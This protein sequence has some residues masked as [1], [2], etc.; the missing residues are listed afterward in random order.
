MILKQRI[1][2]LSI[3]W[4][5]FKSIRIIYTQMCSTV[6]IPSNKLPIVIFIV[7]CYTIF[8]ISSQLSRF[9]NQTMQLTHFVGKN[10]QT[11]PVHYTQNEIHLAIVCA[12]KKF[13]ELAL[14]SIKSIMFNRRKSYTLTFHIFTD[15]A[16]KQLF[17]AYFSSVKN[18][19]THHPLFF[20]T[21]PSRFSASRP[22]RS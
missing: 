15:A 9:Q 10:F 22:R 14:T 11:P 1:P 16:G 8:L 2:L 5:T 12:K 19:R 13:N 20:G 3:L 7:T 21:I 17:N 4:F 6:S 18:M